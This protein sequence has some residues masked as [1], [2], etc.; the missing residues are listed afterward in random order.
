MTKKDLPRVFVAALLPLVLA[1]SSPPKSPA[2]EEQSVR[3][4]ETR[5]VEALDT[6]N[7]AALR[8]LLDESFVDI[9]WKG[10]V[11]NRAAAVAA[12]EAPG[13]PAMKQTLQDMR[14][15]F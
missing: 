11:R 2:Q 7:A 3:D 9:T 8:S 5:W 14:I 10:E 15:R 4:A 6:R 13:R 1:A 12:L